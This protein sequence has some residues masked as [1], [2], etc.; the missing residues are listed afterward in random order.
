VVYDPRFFEVP[1]RML[2][3]EGILAIEFDQSPQRMA[4]ACGLTFKLLLEKRIVQNGDPD[5]AAHVKGAVAVPQERGGFTLKK[6][7]SKGHI[8]GAISMCM[9]VWFLHEVP[10]PAKELWA[11]WQ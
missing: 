1:A 7:K 10:E 9:G 3:G 8:D 6:G 11:A 2:E 5:L 4:P